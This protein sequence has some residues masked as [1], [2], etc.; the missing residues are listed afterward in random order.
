MAAFRRIVLK[1]S[2][3]ALA[4]EKGY[5]FD[6]DALTSICGQI[7]AVHD[8]GVRISIVIGGGNIFRGLKAAAGGMD[9]GTADNMGM[10]ATV[11]NGLALGEAL[12]KQGLASRHMSSLPISGLV[13][14]FIQRK[15]LR[16]LEKGHV[17]VFSGGTGNPYFSTDSAAS[18]R[19]AQIGADVILKGTKVDGVY[20][21]DP[22]KD[23]TLER[24]DVISFSEVLRR[25]LGVMDSTAIAMCRDNSIPIIVFNLTREGDLL[26]VV[27]G[28]KTGTI[29]KEEEHG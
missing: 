6:P 5:G 2:G 26:S 28:E 15:A 12:E 4:G 24:F 18:L 20:A 27:R 7:K 10:M 14:P 19:A 21:G 25:G 9:R 29:I 1:L 8:T 22:V 17:V 3:E 23:P 16:Y 11:I 13:E